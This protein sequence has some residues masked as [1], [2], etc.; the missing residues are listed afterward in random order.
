M[1]CG[2]CKWFTWEEGLVDDAGVCDHFD[3]TI[4]KDHAP[5]APGEAFYAA[6]ARAVAAEAEVNRLLEIQQRGCDCAQSEVCAFARERDEAL[7][8]VER[9]LEPAL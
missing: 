9:P 2:D 8:E 7:A 1:K 6:E 5:C 3:L 4:F